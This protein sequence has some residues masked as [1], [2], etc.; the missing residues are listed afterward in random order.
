[1]K[2]SGKRVVWITGATTG[3]GKALASVF[4]SHGDSVIATARTESRLQELSG[5]IS[6][7]GGLCDP[8]LCDVQNEASVLA[9]A[10]HILTIHGCI[11]ILI[12]NAGVTYFKD[13]LSTSTDEFDHI[14]QTNLR[15]LFLTTKA[16]LPAMI[17]NQNGLVLNI[18]SYVVKEVYTKSAAYSA[19]KAGA[20]AMMDV[21]RSEVRRKGINIVNVYPG[22]VSTPIWN[23]H[24][25]EKFGNQMLAP[26]QVAS[27]LYEVSTQQPSLMV[28]EI[29]LRPQGGDLLL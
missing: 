14:I 24:Q 5:Q 10:K 12:N 18:L 26:E 27:M 11:D 16:V 19:S 7:E 20:E 22:A 1:M 13:F 2:N 6:A 17:E 3:I 9:A 4:A 28:E 23:Q 25:L 15:G 21:L 29:V 8:V